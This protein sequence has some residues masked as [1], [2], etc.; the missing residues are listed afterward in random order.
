MERTVSDLAN[1]EIK[2]V[3][4]KSTHQALLD[5]LINRRK[6]VE[7]GGGISRIETQHA[8]GKLT[9]RER[10]EQLVD[11]SSFQE[12]GA[13]MLH[14]HI[15][16]G[17]DQEHFSGDGLISGF[18]KIDGRTICLFAQDFT[19]MGGSFS[20]VAGRKVVKIMDLAMQAGVPVIGLNDGGGARIQEGVFSLEAF[21]EVFYRNSLASGVIPQISVMLGPCAGGAVYS[22]ALTDF[23]I[24]TQGISNMFITGPEVI[25]A[26][27]GEDVD[28]ESL[29]GADTHTSVSGVAH[30]STQ[31]EEESF[32]LTRRLIGYL[33]SNN[34]EPPPAIVPTD[35]PWRM[36]AAL[37]TFVP[38]DAQTPYDM[39]AILEKVF[40]L[41]SFL[42][43]QGNFAQNCIVGFARLH[44]QSVGVVSQ[45]PMVLAGVIDINASDKIARFVRFCDAF[46]F[47]IITFSDSPG[48]MPGTAQEHSGIIR[49]GAKILYAYSEATV[50][51]LTVITRKGYG[52]AYIVMSSKHIHAD[53]VYAW[54]TAEIAVMG[55][56]GAV[57]ILYRKKLKEANNAKEERAQLIQ[58]YRD[59]FANPYNAAAG[60]HIDDVILPS[61]TRPRLIAALE[62]LRDKQATLPSK[63]HGC[64]PL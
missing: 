38:V 20:E 50:P 10:I 29:G 43:V 24:M 33:P 8:K 44:G 45:Q 34:T 53:L 54:P 46:N 26:V 21:G 16:F 36:D 35:D 25:K 39:R 48:F 51:K 1:D 58:E 40:D 49:H 64:M 22:P 11:E 3:N 47:P 32:K 55:A 23:I 18:A 6:K 41:G 13:Y 59:K 62:L 5:D 56:E 57:N 4:L 37:D 28:V 9:A 42:E 27:T 63:K 60:G 14:R 61:E 31:S 2:P 7:Q 12:L 52:G 30:F 19:V 15:D 17:L